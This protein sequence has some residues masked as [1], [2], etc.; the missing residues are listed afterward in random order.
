MSHLAFSAKLRRANGSKE[1][2]ALAV[3]KKVKEKETSH[4]CSAHHVRYL[5]VPLSLQE[6]KPAMSVCVLRGELLWGIRQTLAQHQGI[7]R[8]ELAAGLVCVWL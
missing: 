5:I 1:G 7:R 3:K 8:C 4:A 2:Y 6:I